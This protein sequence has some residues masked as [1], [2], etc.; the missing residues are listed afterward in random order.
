MRVI[1]DK[2][3]VEK[4]KIFGRNVVAS[5]AAGR[6]E[7]SKALFIPGKPTIHDDWQPLLIARYIPS[8][9]VGQSV[10]TKIV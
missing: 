4:C 3:A 1:V 2:T 7:Q 8:A 9:H 5:Y 10:L 6:K